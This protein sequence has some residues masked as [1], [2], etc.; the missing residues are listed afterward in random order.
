[1]MYISALSTR[2][3]LYFQER[4]TSIFFN[5]AIPNLFSSSPPIPSAPFAV[6][7]LFLFFTAKSAKERQERPKKQKHFVPKSFPFAPF[8]S[9]AV[10]SLFSL[11]PF[12]PSSLYVDHSSQPPCV[13]EVVASSEIY[14]NGPE[15]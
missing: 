2:Y 13:R 12:F 11:N 7:F 6:K 9:F 15:G 5:T 10:N 8:A 1:M 3:S 14:L 4:P